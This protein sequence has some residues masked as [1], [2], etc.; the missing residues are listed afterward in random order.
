MSRWPNP[1]LKRD[2][3]SRVLF[4]NRITT[5]DGFYEVVVGGTSA[6]IVLDTEHVPVENESHRILH[7]VGLTYFPATS[8]A[9]MIN[10]SIPR[11]PCLGDF[12]E[13]YQLQSLTLNIEL[14]DQLQKDLIRFRGYVPKRRLSRFAQER[15]INLGS[16]APT[17]IEFIQSCSSSDPNINFYFPRTF[18]KAI[19]YFSS[20]TDLRDIGKYIALAK[21]LPA[22]ISMP[23]TFGY[24]WKDIKGSY[25]HC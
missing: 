8:M 9:M 20:W 2:L 1:S 4:D 18:P 16:L 13:R 12:Y 15:Q 25:E 22:R 14:S 24:H 11:R 7:Q 3:D 21:F 5:M 23:Q 19:P 6:F 10:T 17:I